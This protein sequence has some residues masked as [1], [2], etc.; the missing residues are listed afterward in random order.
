MMKQ[1]KA[2]SVSLVFCFICNS[3]K[4][5]QYE[6]NDWIE[7][8]DVSKWASYN[9][10][11]N[12]F[13][14]E[15]NK[16]S[17]YYELLIVREY[18]TTNA[19]NNILKDYSTQFDS[20]KQNAKM[21]IPDLRT[22][23]LPLFNIT[24]FGIKIVQPSSVT[25]LR[26]NFTVNEKKFSS[27]GRS[28]IILFA[29]SNDSLINR[30]IS[31][32]DLVAK[33][34]SNKIVYYEFG[35]VK[36]EEDFCWKLQQLI[37]FLNELPEPK[38]KD[39]K[40]S[41][42]SIQI[43]FGFTS[44]ISNSVQTKS[45]NSNYDAFDYSSESLNSFQFN[46]LKRIGGKISYD[47]LINNKIKKLY[48][49]SP[50]RI[51]IGI[52]YAYAK[53]LLSGSISSFSDKLIINSNGLDQLNIYGSNINERF[54]L[55]N[56]RIGGEFRLEREINTPNKGSIK[57]S[58]FGFSFIPYAILG[59]YFDARLISGEFSYK[60]KVDGV[61]GEIENIESLGLQNNITLNKNR[62]SSGLFT[63]M[64]A[65]LRLFYSFGN[66]KIGFSIFP[67]VS[68]ESLKNKKEQSTDYLMT[69]GANDYTPS[70]LNLQ[71]IQ[72]NSLGLGFSIKFPLGS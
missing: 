2:L 4:S 46:L 72:T 21:A 66:D 50:L 34:V 8:I 10:D 71:R 42:G 69:R 41:R 70:L 55:S 19:Y 31:E 7:T 47:T 68:V 30:N 32:L 17:K 12:A 16:S 58:S 59:S 44:N 65:T 48:R 36:S 64:G 11:V 20:L 5:Q 54:T 29:N 24:K 33:R 14:D 56:H 52:Q 37:Y 39:A 43:D 51:S 38:I 57:F 61:A 1:L 15:A 23:C 60:G 28:N 26:C 27:S 3:L 25:T 63:G 18:S 9:I 53:E 45:Y 13:L 49:Y 22:L 67:F 40:P 6:P 62:S 35:G